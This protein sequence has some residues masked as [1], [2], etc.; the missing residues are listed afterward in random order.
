[1]REQ[2]SLVAKSHPS[3]SGDWFGAVPRSCR[4]L[5]GPDNGAGRKE[6][7]RDSRGRDYA[8]RG[9]SR[10]NHGGGFRLVGGDSKRKSL[11]KFGIVVYWKITEAVE[12]G[13]I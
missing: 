9:V 11:F 13:G 2:P 1:M 12:T 3:L 4:S 5:P 7:A 8:A 10:V 6:G